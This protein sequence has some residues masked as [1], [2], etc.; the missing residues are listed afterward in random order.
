MIK[1]LKQIFCIHIYE[2]DAMEEIGA[3]LECRKCGDSKTQ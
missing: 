2:Y 3:H 1:L